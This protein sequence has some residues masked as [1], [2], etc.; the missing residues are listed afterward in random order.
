MI[1]W[2]S[3]HSDTGGEEIAEVLRTALRRLGRKQLLFLYPFALALLNTV[4]FVAVYAATGGVIRWEAFAEANFSRWSYLQDNLGNM[5]GSFPVLAV[6]A[7]IGVA[8]CLLAAMLRAPFFRAVVGLGY[9]RAPSSAQEILRLALFYLITYALTLALPYSFPEDSFAFQ[10]AGLAALGIA[11]LL[12]FGDYVIVFESIGP[13]QAAKR[14][15]YLLRRGWVP[16]LLIFGAALIL[17]QLIY[18]LYGSFYDRAD[19]VFVLLPIS[20]LLVESLVTVTVDVIL[21]F[22]YDYL[23]RV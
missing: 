1:Y 7:F 9:P 23:R 3:R 11:L 16:V 15:F 8:V 20:R 2:R 12:V 6:V 17:W 19:G 10:G 14:S 18:M 22:S 21:I 13:W 5:V 4:A